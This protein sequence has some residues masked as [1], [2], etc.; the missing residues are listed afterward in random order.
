MPIGSLQEEGTP[1]KKI[2]ADTKSETGWLPIWALRR[3]P[4]CPSS[5]ARGTYL[6]Y[7]I[8]YTRQQS[9]QGLRCSGSWATGDKRENPSGIILDLFDKLQGISASYSDHQDCD[10][11]GTDRGK[12]AEYQR[13]STVFDVERTKKNN[14]N[15]VLLLRS[16]PLY[17]PPLSTLIFASFL[18]LSSYYFLLALPLFADLS[19]SSFL[20]P[21]SS[22]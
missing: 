3:Q 1:S 18:L 19:P 4:T 12:Q 8:I 15:R 9:C 20:Q 6:W 13:F 17:F 10:V 11:K 14:R 5:F 21:D 22:Y 16:Y 2:R 7:N